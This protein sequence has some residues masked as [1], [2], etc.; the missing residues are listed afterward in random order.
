MYDIS[1]TPAHEIISGTIMALERML[2]KLEIAEEGLS[3][4]G[5]TKITRQ[6]PNKRLERPAML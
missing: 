1:S 6:K 4:S 3:G 2:N 5:S